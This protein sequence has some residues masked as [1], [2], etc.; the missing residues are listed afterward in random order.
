L[1]EAEYRV[2]IE[3][4]RNNGDVLKLIADELGGVNDAW[5]GP[6]RISALVRRRQLGKNNGRSQAPH[7]LGPYGV[8]R[9][10]GQPLYRYRV[11]KAAFELMR[12]NLAGR[13]AAIRSGNGG[14]RDA[15]LFV[16]WAAEWFRRRYDGNILRWA[17]LGACIGLQLE[18]TAWRRLAD[19]GLKYWGIEELHLNGTHH[20]LVAIARQGGFPVAALEGGENGWASRY[21]QGLV[22]ALLAESDSTTE[23]AD[24]L[25][26]GHI[27]EIPLTWRNEEMRAV[28]AELAVAVTALRREAEM[29]GVTARTLVSAWLD[30]HHPDWRDNLPV[31]IDDDGGRAL[32]DG[33][34]AATV[35]SHATI[36][37]QRILRI[38]ESERREQVELTLDGLLR[39]AHLQDLATEWNRLR[40]F[41]SGELARHITG[42][43]GVAEPAEDG[44]VVRPV[45]IRRR[46][47]VPFATAVTVELRGEGLRKGEP[48]TLSGGEPVGSGLRVCSREAG[49]Q[50]GAFDLRVVGGGTGGYRGAELYL[51]V[52]A[53]WRAGI[54]NAESN[55]AEHLAPG[56]PRGRRLWRM[57]GEVLVTSPKDDKFLIRSGQSGDQRDRLL[58]TGVAPRGC[59]LA[60]GGDLRQGSPGF[61]ICR[62][63]AKRAPGAGEVWWRRDGERAWRPYSGLADLGPCEFAWRDAQTGYIRSRADAVVLPDEFAIKRE[64]KSD[65]STLS[66][67]GWPYEVSV[68]GGEPAG[69]RSWRFRIAA[70]ARSQC[71]ICLV[72]SDGRNALLRTWLP[73]IAWISHWTEGPAPATSQISL[74]SLNRY[75]ARA[76]GKCVLLAELRDGNGQPM[77]QGQASWPFDD[78]LPLTSIFDD[79][80]ALVRSSGE[81]DAQ[82]RLSFIGGQEHTYWSV[83]EFGRGPDGLA[84]VVSVS[85]ES[86]RVMGRDLG[87]PAVEHDFGPASA[88]ATS[89][90]PPL[91]GTW[92][93][94]LRANDRV[95][96]RPRLLPGEPAPLPQNSLL[97]RAM[98]IRDRD[99]RRLAL[100]QLI[101]DVVADPASAGSRQVVREIAEL[102]QSLNGLPPSTFEVFSRLRSYP[103]LGPL[104][105]FSVA[106]REV[107]AL[108]RLADGLNLAWPLVPRACW[109]SAAE[110]EG[111]RLWRLLPDQLADIA[112][113]ISGQRKAIAANDPILAPLFNLPTEVRTVLE[114]ANMFLNAWGDRIRNDAP[115]PFRP[116]FA[117]SLPAWPY[118]EAYWR[119][120][121]APIVAA[122]V[123]GGEFG[124]IGIEGV[125]CVKDV[126]RSHPQYFAQAYAAAL[127][128]T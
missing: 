109:E 4:A 77:A 36:S 120:L 31:A 52:P 58:L 56:D 102:A 44:W 13:A 82:A 48:F 113:A 100:D 22:G 117:A 21:L 40:L 99:A 95:L 33:L 37:A 51:D 83:T 7:W 59:E 20:R 45:S 78:E 39:N 38:D 26:V 69:E 114:A 27:E 25:A 101:Q 110:T 104:L 30:Q 94:Y 17:T 112:G 107:D 118:G 28:C 126:A 103:L 3:A 29:C 115:N 42:E 19:E 9:I 5:A 127:S 121:D 11:C 16:L 60:G 116:K 80:A 10:V 70:A 81:L 2:R 63:V 106:D 84:A 111:Q 88:E 57:S 43:L 53:D 46:F 49:V 93:V 85:D 73:Q 89:A 41:A 71:E 86:A 12:D 6:L 24:R 108:L 32:V 61:F 55:C 75:V 96:S 79:V 124:D 34:I 105:M 1:S 66:V 23:A 98:I 123:A 87:A 14:H 8:T 67:E 68:E 64:R 92:L 119:A 15:A 62:G 18:Q 128:G 65:W 74:S 50:S 54:H 91:M 125:M 72:L 76:P 90:L 97:A 47:D 35:R 122:K